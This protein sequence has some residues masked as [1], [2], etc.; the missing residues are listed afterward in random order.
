MTG[1]VKKAD[2]ILGVV[3]DFLPGCIIDVRFHPLLHGVLDLGEPKEVNSNEE[4]QQVG[5]AD[6]DKVSTLASVAPLNDLHQVEHDLARDE[7]GDRD[8]ALGVV[9]GGD[10]ALEDAGQL[11]HPRNSRFLRVVICAET[12]YTGF[13]LVAK[14]K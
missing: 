12:L 6:Q 14:F 2:N 5:Q 4:V 1:C 7:V 13:D 11:H 9:S 10:H 3:E 8:G